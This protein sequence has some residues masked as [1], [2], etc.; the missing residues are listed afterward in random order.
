MRNSIIYYLSNKNNPPKPPIIPPHPPLEKG[1]RGD[2]KKR[3]KGGLLGEKGL[4]LIEVM[5]AIVVLAIGL[6]GV[7]MMQYMAVAGNSFGREMQIATELGQERLEMIKATA[8]ANVA[9]ANESLTDPDP[10]RFGGLT[11][12]RRWWVANNCRNI[13]V[14]LNPNN[15]CDPNSAVNCA[16]AMNNMRAVAVR[17]CWVDKNGGNHSVTLNGVKW[18]ETA[19]P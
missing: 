3:G 2:L 1:G 12:T 8:Y 18:D 17:V 6:I 9:S 10:S 13:N 5:V 14:A 11:F 19:T 16:D 7:A 15:P 4:T